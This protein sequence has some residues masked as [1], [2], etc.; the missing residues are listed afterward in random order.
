MGTLPMKYLGIPVSFRCLKN[1]D[2]NYVDGIFIKKLD[3]WVGGTSSSGGRLI[4]V[5]YCLSNLPSYIKAMFLPN[6]TFIEKLDKHR[7]LLLAR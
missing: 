7:R 1:T 2:L 3:V 6:K 5:D 4:L